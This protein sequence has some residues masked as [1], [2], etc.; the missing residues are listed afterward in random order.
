[1]QHGRGPSWASNPHYQFRSSMHQP[2]GQLHVLPLHLFQCYQIRSK[3]HNL[4]DTEMIFI[5]RRVAQEKRLANLVL[6]ISKDETLLVVYRQ[7]FS[8]NVHSD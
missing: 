5:K 2:L 7:N 1:M 8:F 3:A 6:K 4:N